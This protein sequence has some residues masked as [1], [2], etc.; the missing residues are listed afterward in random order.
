MTSEA[1]KS[2]PIVN[3]DAFPIIQNAIGVGHCRHSAHWQWSY[4]LHDR[5]HQRV[6][7]SAGSFSAGERTSNV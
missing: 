5:R 7:L 2:I 4:C 6:D 3:L 1:L